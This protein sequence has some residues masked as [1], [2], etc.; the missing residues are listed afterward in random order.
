MSD[1][2]ISYSSNDRPWVERFAKT[3]ESHGWSVWWDREIPTGGSFNQVIRQ[4]LGEAKCAIVVWSDQSVESEWV[5]AEAAEAKRQEKYLPI[6]ITQSEI[7]LGFTQRT[8]QSLVDWETGVDHAGFSQLLK[9]I[10]RLVKDPP[11][12]IEFAPT[13][14]W[15]RVHP[16]WMISGPTILAA[17]VALGLMLW[18]LS[19]RVQVELTTERVEF[20]IGAKQSQDSFTL[21]G[22]VAESVGI[23]NFDA[24]TLAPLKIEVADPSLYQ[25]EEDRFPDKAWRKLALTESELTVTANRQAQGS[26]VVV[27]GQEAPIKLDSIVARPGTRIS[28]ETREKEQREKREENG[29]TATKENNEKR[30]GVTIKVAGQNEFIFRPGRQFTLITDHVEMRV[31]TSLPFRQEGEL[32]FRITLPEQPSHVT[33]KAR[34]DELV[35]LPTFVIGPS[36]HR[37]FGGIPA[38]TLDFTRQAGEADGGRQTLVKAGE[39]ISALT[40]DGTITFPGY[41]Q[42]LGKV[43]MRQDEAVGLEYLDGFTIQEL[44]LTPDGTGIYLKG[45]GMAKE[46]RTRSGQIPIQRHRLTMLDVLWHNAQLA[47]IIAIIVTVFTASLGAYRLWKEF[48]R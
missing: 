35:L 44:S 32:T 10:E 47:V 6:K 13:P 37:I 2:F 38:T 45:E 11:R 41:E 39:R 31:L 43:S 25:L 16:V 40:G 26:R 34:S 8:Y 30:E 27:E 7:P 46:I 28:L 36:A 18:P 12:Q 48:K 15:K 5:Q 21:S 20:V 33:V 29:R 4:Q 9:D 23:E 42:L 24:I 14:W 17:I 22:M 3:L 1:I 19:A